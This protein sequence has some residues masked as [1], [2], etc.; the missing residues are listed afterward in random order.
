[1]SKGQYISRRIPEKQSDFMREIAALGK[2]Y[3]QMGKHFG[4][5]F[6]NG[7]ALFDKKRCY[8]RALQ[9]FLQSSLPVNKKKGMVRA[10]AENGKPDIFS[11]WCLSVFL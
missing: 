4:N 5:S 7:V 3:S 9:P 2:S 11:N 10:A 6:V 1:M 8:I